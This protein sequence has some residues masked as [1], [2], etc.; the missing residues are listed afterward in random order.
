MSFRLDIDATGMGDAFDRYEAFNEVRVQRAM[1][2][3]TGRGAR[4]LQSLVR[5]EMASAGLGRLGQAYAATSD[6]DRRQGVH[7]QADGFS[8]SGMLYVRARSERT[9]G[10]LAAYTRG[11]E[12][13]PQRGRWLW[14]PTDDIPLRANDRTR[15]TPANWSSSGLDRK[16]GPLVMIRSVN[17]YPLLVVQNA[18]VALSGR[19][20]SAKSLTK[21]G[22]T[23]KGQTGRAFIVA[24]IGIPRTARAARVDVYALHRQ[25]M[26]E[27]PA[28]FETEFRKA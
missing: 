5:G 16:I 9:R 13:Q 24:F 17:G 3:A 10:T 23:K 27:L 15:L 19:A 1:L 6:E 8:A 18:S 2:A 20:R 28:I 11:A 14:V 25:V 21:T 12:I 4:R 22:R 26:A 7:H